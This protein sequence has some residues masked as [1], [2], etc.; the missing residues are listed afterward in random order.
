MKEIFD[1]AAEVTDEEFDKILRAFGEGVFEQPASWRTV[2]NGRVT[3]SVRAEESEHAEVPLVLTP[4]QAAR[5]R[6][7]QAANLF[8]INNRRTRPLRRQVLDTEISEDR[9]DFSTFGNRIFKWVTMEAPLLGTRQ[10]QRAVCICRRNSLL[11]VEVYV[12]AG[13]TPPVAVS[14]RFGVLPKTVRHPLS[15]RERDLVRR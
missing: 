10:L 11:P 15:R 5:L 8:M 7:I 4:R 3:R 1:E 6:I 2:H 9:E 13:F 12:A 14:H